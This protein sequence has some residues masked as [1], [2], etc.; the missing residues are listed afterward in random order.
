[1]VDQSVRDQ[2]QVIQRA[3]SGCDTVVAAGALQIATRSIAELLNIRYVFVGYAPVAFP[4]ADLPPA[5][6]TPGRSDPAIETDTRALWSAEAQR[7]NAR[8]LETLNDERARLGFAPVDDIMRHIFTDRLWLA[9][10]PV[11]GPAPANSELRI[12]QT[13]AWFM[14]DDSILPESLQ[15]F[16]DEGEPPI[17][18]GFGSMRGAD[19][20]ASRLVEAA[21]A[22]GR[23]A[24]LFQGWSNLAPIDSGP[25]C[26]G[27]GDVNHAEL[28][29][30]VA[31]VVH[32]GGAGTTQAAARAGCPQVIVP[33]IY[34]QFYW[35]HRVQTLGVGC[36]GPTRDELTTQA[37]VDVLREALDP[38]T[39]RQAQ[40]IASRMEQRGVQIAAQR[41]IDQSSRAS[42]KAR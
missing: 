17:Y 23:R 8:F 6:T 40:L 34:D 21:R 35:G 1:M 11:L 37:L 22:L 9:S 33:H 18:F 2:F 12:V 28:F 26:I 3:A 20:T 5:K 42:E 14:R 41:L 4:S 16:L 24:V 38:S 27:I 10:D 30:R 19:R 36:V 29:R 13:G 32:H 7:W 39:A 31:V 15:R 25:D